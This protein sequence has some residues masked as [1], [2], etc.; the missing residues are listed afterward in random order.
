MLS[1]LTTWVLPQCS[2]VPP[3]QPLSC[4]IFIPGTCQEISDIWSR[5]LWCYPIRQLGFCH[6][7][8]L[9]LLNNHFHV[10]FIPGTCQEISDILSRCL[11]CY[12]IRQLG[13]RHSAALFLLNNHFH[14]EFIP[15]TCQEI[16]DI[17]S[18]CLWYYPI[19]Q[20]GFCHSAALFLPTNQILMWNLFRGLVK[21]L[22]T[23]CPGACDTVLSDNLGSA[24]AQHCSS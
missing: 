22:V 2:T 18:R 1:Y 8:A 9:F 6:S 15:G 12:P 4:G 24:T 14:V 16:S 7:P 19:R 5:C 20:L 23:F 13:F 10:K 11:W 3:K 21:R 17:L